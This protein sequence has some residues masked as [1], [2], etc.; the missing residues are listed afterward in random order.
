MNIYDI[1]RLANVSIA[2]VSRV[3]N[4]SPKVSANTRQKV[5]SVMEEVGYTP[6]IFAR[7]LGLDSM[8]TIGILCPDIADIYMANAVSIL[9]K[10]LN[11]RGY[12]CILG[13]SG[14]LQED[15]E[16]YCQLK[17]IKKGWKYPN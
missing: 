12:D 5:L 17:C 3:V 6:N 11:L 14:T 8:K 16:K 1:A 2:T 13:C 7:G 10:E 15:K 9:E 4:G